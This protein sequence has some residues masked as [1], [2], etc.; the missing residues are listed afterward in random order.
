MVTLFSPNSAV[1][2]Y[3]EKDVNIKRQ[4]SSQPIMEA[5][6]QTYEY[7]TYVIL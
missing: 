3:S 2:Y 1:I 7:Y 6:Y 4:E 5:G